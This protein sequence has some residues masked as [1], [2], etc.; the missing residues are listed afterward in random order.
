M[1][2]LRQIELYPSYL[3]VTHGRLNGMPQS[4]LLAPLESLIICTVCTIQHSIRTYVLP[5]LLYSGRHSG[6]NVPIMH[7]SKSA[8]V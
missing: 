3:F 1:F 7:G 6:A 2:A 8:R 5:G 4:Y